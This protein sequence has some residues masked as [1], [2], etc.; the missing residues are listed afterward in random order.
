M[1]HLL[2]HFEGKEHIIWDWNGTLLD[3]VDFCIEIIA[4]ML[5]D[6]G[7]PALDKNKYLKRFRFPIIDYYAELGFRFDLVPFAELSKHFISRYKEGMASRTQLYEGVRDILSELSNRGV[8]CSML[9]A[10]HEGDLLKLLEKHGLRDHFVHVYGLGD[11][12]AVSKL[13]RG[14]ELMQVIST[15]PTAVLLVGD[16]NHDLEVGAAMGIDVLLVSGGH[17]CHDRL[18]SVHPKVVRRS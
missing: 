17:Q 18:S 2:P 1:L 12:H 6:H 13:Q 3:D 15:P 11:H 7:L 5:G 4:A 10:N 16:T 8:A 9:S 14:K